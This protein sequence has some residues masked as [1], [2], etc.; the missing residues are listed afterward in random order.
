MPGGI[1][2]IGDL[3]IQEDG[4]EITSQAIGDKA[5]LTTCADADTIEV[6]STTGKLQ[7]KA[8]GSSKANGVGRDDMSKYAGF[9]IKGAL[10]TSDGGGGVFSVENTYGTNLAILRAVIQVTTVAGDNCTI[11]IGVAANGTTSAATL[12]DGLDVNSAV[13]VFDNIDDQGTDGQSCLKWPSGEFINGSVKTGAASGLVGTY[14][15]HA[16]D[17]N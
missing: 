14:A 15:I 6:S 13:G 12:I 1:S 4:G 10:A 17:M 7:I 2:Y 8:A 5:L 9:W 11:D 3:T 16:I